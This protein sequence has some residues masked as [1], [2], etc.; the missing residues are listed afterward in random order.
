MLNLDKTVRDVALEVPQATRV[1]EK[2]RID[3]CCGGQRLLGEACV[4][5]SVDPAALE[6]MI[7][8]AQQ[9]ARQHDG[10][11]LQRRSLSELIDYILDTHHVFTRSEST[12]LQALIKKVVT[13][14]GANHPELREIRTT[15]KSLADDLVT[16][17]LKEERMLFPYIK[18]LEAATRKSNLRPFAPFGT[19][20]NPVR[21]MMLEHDTAGDLL[22]WLRSL[23]SDYTVPPDACLSFQTLYQALEN[24]EHDLHQHIHLENNLLFPRAVELESSLTATA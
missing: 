15:F 17:M 2:L 23:S 4:A 18:A 14:H 20:V 8:E 10:F 3:Y 24:F 19:V 16:H 5:A 6:S 1:F 22:R 7:R 11:D 13:A 21:M 12:R 9:T